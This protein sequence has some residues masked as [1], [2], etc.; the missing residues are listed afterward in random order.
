MSGVAKAE[1]EDAMAASQA[2]TVR[3]KRELTTKEEKTTPGHF[4]VPYTDIYETDEALVLVM[5]VPGVEREKVNVALEND[6]LHVEGK[7]DFSK[8]HGLE[9]LYTEYNVGHYA[10]S[11]SLSERIDKGAIKAELDSGVLK[12]TLP[13]SADSRPRRIAIE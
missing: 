1:T 2:M 12:I 5:E 4:Y 9:P 8:Y 13:K 7:I 10:R 3:D 11:F 6:V